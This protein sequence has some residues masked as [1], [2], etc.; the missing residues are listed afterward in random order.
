MQTQV[1]LPRKKRILVVDDEPD[2][3]DLLATF[4]GSQYDVITARDGVEGIELAQKYHPD[5]IITDVSMPRLGGLDMIR[6]LRASFG[7]RVPIFFVSGQNAPGDIIAGISA[8]ARH[9]LSKPVERP[10]LKKRIA[11]A[12]GQ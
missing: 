2:W 6:H 12:L 3:S 4:L 11:R 7:V 1:A 10:D 5:L 9:Y 8:G